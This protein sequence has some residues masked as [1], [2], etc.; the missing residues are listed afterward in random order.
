MLIFITTNNPYN[1]LTYCR[2]GVDLL[3]FEV[4]PPHEIGV[5]H[6]Q[7]VHPTHNRKEASLIAAL[8]NG[9]VGPED[10]CKVF[11]FISQL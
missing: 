4:F 1:S 8:D 3:L 10:A 6:A 7:V 2:D 5:G 9:R 11:S